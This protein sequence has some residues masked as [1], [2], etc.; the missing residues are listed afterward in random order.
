MQESK[1]NARSIGARIKRRRQDEGLAQS[2]L[3]MRLNVNQSTISRIERGLVVKGQAA[4]RL[5]E[6][7]DGSEERPLLEDILEKISLSPELRALVQRVLSES[8]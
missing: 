6:Y 2:V 5:R 7:A 4:L 3:A 1:N 8:S